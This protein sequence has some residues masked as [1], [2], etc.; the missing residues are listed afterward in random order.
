[1]DRPRLI[2]GLRISWGVAWGMLCVRVCGP[3]LYACAVVSPFQG[4]GVMWGW[5]PRAAACA[6]LR[7]A[8]PCPG[9]LYS[10]PAEL[11][12][13]V[14]VVTEEAGLRSKSVIARQK[15]RGC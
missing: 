7:L 12:A 15:Y 9:L 10:A 8:W 14:A 1:M 6:R 13:T 11:G 2:R 4:F 5:E 3:R